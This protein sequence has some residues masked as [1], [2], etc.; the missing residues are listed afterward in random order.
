MERLINIV[1]NIAILLLFGFLLITIFGDLANAEPYQ[2]PDRH[3]SGAQNCNGGTLAG[4][5]YMAVASK[6]D[7]RLI[8]LCMKVPA[9]LPNMALD[10][11]IGTALVHIADSDK[12]LPKVLYLC[13]EDIGSFEMLVVLSD[14]LTG[15]EY[16]RVVIYP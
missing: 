6:I 16:K 11:A 13:I 4:K 15:M 3:W 5:H 14:A 10:V 8:T 12:N 9:K 2:I 1:L 7:R